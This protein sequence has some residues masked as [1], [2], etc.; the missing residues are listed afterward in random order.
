MKK[1]QKNFQRKEWVGQ[2]EILKLLNNI[3]MC[4]SCQKK[5]QKA[6]SAGGAR[7]AYNPKP[8]RKT[9]SASAHPF[10]KPKVRMSFSSRNK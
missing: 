1:K 6:V 2:K 7:V 3:I 10:G 8:T 5:N 4:M 9:F